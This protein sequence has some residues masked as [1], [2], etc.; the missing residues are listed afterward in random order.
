[1]FVCDQSSAK[2]LHKE[3]PVRIAHR[4]KGFRSLPFIIGCNP[5]IL[6]VVSTKLKSLTHTFK[7]ECKCICVTEMYCNKL[8]SSKSE[9]SV[10]LPHCVPLLLQAFYKIKHVLHSTCQLCMCCEADL[11]PSLPL[12]S[13][14]SRSTLHKAP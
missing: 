14:G 2:Y 12:S 7:T 1:M 3:L 11:S 6:Q 4:I 9:E 5:T 10:T 8:N 13:H